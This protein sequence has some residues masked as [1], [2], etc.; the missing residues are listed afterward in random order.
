MRKRTRRRGARLKLA[1]AVASL[2]AVALIAAGCGGDDDDGDTGDTGGAPEKITVTL[3]FQDSI[4]WTGYEISKGPDGEFAEVGLEPETAAV[5]GNSYTVQQLIS[6]KV[7]FAV[8]GAPE[9]M[10]ANARGNELYGIGALESD[11]FTIGALE[12]S[13]VTSIEDLDGQALGITDP[14]GGEIPL[15][16]AALADAGLEED[17][18]V[19]LKV[20]GEG[21]ATV[22]KALENGEIAAFAG[23]INDFVPLESAGLT[24]TT[25]VSDKFAGTP[26]DYLVVTADTYNDETE[27]EKVKNLLK[28]WYVGV[29]YGE[30]YPEDGLARICEEVPE[31]CEDPEFADGFYDASIG[32]SIDEARAGG[33]PDYEAL[34]TVRDAVAA[35]DVPEA[36]DVDVETIFPDDVCQ[37]LVPS[38]DAVSAFAERT[39]ATG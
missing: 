20:V 5:D 29:V 25:I 33:C 3:P 26:N 6:G 31:D 23:A 17:K 24:F 13:G 15:V 30:Q 39:G 22:V 36:A 16:K 9:A 12:D 32:I 1:F 7:P 8:T 2:G 19:E 14:G 37:D 21:G 34:T 4:V 11:I 38:E 28:A 18:D 35:A 27:M 10:I